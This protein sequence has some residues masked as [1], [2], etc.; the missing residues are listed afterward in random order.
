MKYNIQIEGMDC[1]DCALHL[2]QDIK[3]L[4]GIKQVKVHFIN[5]N[6]QFDL[7]GDQSTFDNVRKIVEKSGYGKRKENRTGNPNLER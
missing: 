7:D 2:E 3:A 5:K 4:P 1:A 6:L